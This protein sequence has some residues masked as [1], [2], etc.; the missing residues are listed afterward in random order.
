M[1]KF[2]I[3]EEMLYKSC[4]NVENNLLE[5]LP[6]EDDLNY[7]FSNRFEHKIKKLIKREKRNPIDNKIYKYSKRVAALLVVTTIGLFTLTMSVEAL[8]N[9]FFEVMKE[10]YYKFTSYVFSTTVDIDKSDLEIVFPKYLPEGFKEVDRLDGYNEV[11]VT[12]KNNDGEDITYQNYKINDVHIV[13]DTEDIDKEIILLNNVE[14]EYYVKDNMNKLI[15]YD[16]EKFYS[17]SLHSIENSKIK[18]KKKELLSI[19]ESIK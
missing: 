1:N 10:V 5:Q 8:R 6:K 3:T 12:Y 9:Q 15:W 19:A 11:I 18:D 16:D 14:A 13:N 17:I 7:S 2:E 4:E